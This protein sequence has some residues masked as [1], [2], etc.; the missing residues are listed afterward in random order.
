[1]DNSIVDV[2][3]CVTTKNVEDTIGIC[4]DSVEDFAE[5]IVVLDCNST[6]DTI[7]ICESYTNN[8]YQHEFEGFTKLF[9]TAISKASNEW[10]LLLDADEEVSRS[11]K[12]EIIE[13]LSS[14]DAVAYKVP[15]K[16]NMFGGWVKTN[17]TKPSLAMSK[18]ITFEEDYIHPQMTVKEE[19]GQDVKK[20]SGHINHYTYDRV[21]E[22]MEK[23]DQYT[24]LEAL[25]KFESDKRYKL[26][27]A[28]AKGF[29][30]C[31]Y[32]LIF[33]KSLLDGYRGLLFATMSFQY[34]LVTYSK[35]K[36]L[37]R[38]KPEQW[39]NIWLEEECQR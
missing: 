16:T 2:S 12:E 11:L 3:V 32:H 35:T 39:K 31:F 9:E 36:D 10:V 18:A 1:M 4:L 14:P 15:F 13:K 38:I 22:Y 8:I 21:S 20:L 37:D 30:V 25:R 33:N 29:G 26:Y 27:Q 23:F 6:D 5:E 17:T 19:Y 7:D 34:Q 24:A 28:L